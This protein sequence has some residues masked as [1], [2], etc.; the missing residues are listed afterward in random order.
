MEHECIVVKTEEMAC[1]R[2]FLDIQKIIP[3][4]ARVCVRSD[5]F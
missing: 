3:I 1:V 2:C 5:P 4:A